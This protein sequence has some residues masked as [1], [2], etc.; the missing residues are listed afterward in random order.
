MS[1]LIYQQGIFSYGSLNKGI[2][3]KDVWFHL[4]SETLRTDLNFLRNVNKIKEILVLRPLFQSSAIFLAD[5]ASFISRL[6][7]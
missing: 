7:R 2:F 6:A 5:F 4:P 1:G 3:L